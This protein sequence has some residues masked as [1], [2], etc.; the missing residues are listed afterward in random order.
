MNIFDHIGFGNIKNEATR[1]TYSGGDTCIS[2]SQ[3]NVYAEIASD[4]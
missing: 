1:K 3:K 4:E 2:P